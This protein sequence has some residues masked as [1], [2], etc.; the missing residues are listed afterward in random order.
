MHPPIVSVVVPSYNGEER[1]PTL[2]SALAEQTHPSFEVVVVLDGSMDGSESTIENFKAPFPLRAVKRGNGGRAA[3]RNTGVEVA[4]GRFL[5]FYDDDMEPEPDSI[6]RH[7]DVLNRFKSAISVG[8]Q[9]EKA[10]DPT[11]FTTFKTYLTRRWVAHLGAEP[12]PLSD[13]ELLLTAANMAIRKEDF[14]RLGGFDEGL[15]DAED[16]DLAVRAKTTGME[17]VFDPKNG[18]HHRSFR[19]FSDYILRQRQYREAHRILR[20]KRKSHPRFDLYT[21]YEVRTSPFKKTIYFVVPGFVVRFV[22]NGGLSWMKPAWKYP[23]YMRIISA[24]SVYYPKR[25]L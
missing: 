7:A 11:E 5:V 25:K 6:V 10:E 19:T 9:L 3:A 22:D 24:L 12:A 15:K 16:F 4:R 13:K 17:V 2:L 20:S 23:I 18:G 14:H 21:K 8:Q 1:L